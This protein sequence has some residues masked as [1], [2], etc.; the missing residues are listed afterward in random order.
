MPLIK[1]PQNEEA[2]SLSKGRHFIPETLAWHIWDPA[3]I[4]IASRGTTKV[5]DG[6]FVFP[7]P[8]LRPMRGARREGYLGSRVFDILGKNGEGIGR[9][10]EKINRTTILFIARG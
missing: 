10:L 3:L 7:I 4:Q 5:A 8:F 6:I 9:Y 2:R 1:V